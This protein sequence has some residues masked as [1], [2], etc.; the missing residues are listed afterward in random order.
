VDVLI[1]LNPSYKKEILPYNKNGNYL[2]L[3]KVKMGSFVNYHNFMIASTPEQ[4][5]RG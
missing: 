3:P 4:Y 1:R 5:I 2:I